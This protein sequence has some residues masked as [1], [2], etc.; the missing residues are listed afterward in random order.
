VRQDAG[1][2]ENA[3]NDKAFQSRFLRWAGMEAM[4]R[5]AFAHGHKAKRGGPL[6][7]SFAVFTKSENQHQ[8][9]GL[10]HH[11]GCWLNNQDSKAR[12]VKYNRAAGPNQQA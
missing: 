3:F 2:S 8:P 1:N 10:P 6:A 11:P 12:P 7:P 9:S 5:M 4:G